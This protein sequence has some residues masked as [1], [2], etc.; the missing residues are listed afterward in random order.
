MV[1]RLFLVF[2]GDRERRGKRVQLRGSRLFARRNLQ[3]FRHLRPQSLEI[4]LFCFRLINRLFGKL[5]WRWIAF[6]HFELLLDRS[7]KTC[8]CIYEHIRGC[9]GECRNR[10]AKGNDR[11]KHRA[12][13][14][15]SI[16]RRQ[17]PV[18]LAELARQYNIQITASW[19]CRSATTSR[20]PR[21]SW[22]FCTV[23]RPNSEGCWALEP[24]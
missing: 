10:Q 12:I 7:R 11:P 23:Q 5:R 17:V 24:G 22:R 4:G 13:I 15:D 14:S 9:A 19:T 21:G 8:S 2:T 3:E 1:R 6:E 16:G 20:R 18:G